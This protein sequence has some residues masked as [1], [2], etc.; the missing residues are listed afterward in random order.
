MKRGE[1]NTR[2]PFRVGAYR[3]IYLWGGPGTIRMN[4]LKFMNQPVDED[5]H[6]E[7]HRDQG[8][9]R[10]LEDLYCNWV[11]LMYNWGFPP[12]IEREDWE[13]FRRA[14]KLYHHGGSKVFAYVQ[15]SN[16]VYQGSFRQKD[17][18]AR[19]HRG[20]K[21]YYYS[22]RYM[23]CLAHP[24]WVEHLKGI[25]RGAIERGAD[26]IFFDNLWHGEMPISLF[27]A[28]LGAAGCH[29]ER[30]KAAYIQASG[31]PIPRMIQTG[32]PAV[33][34]Y[35]RW[36]A[37]QVTA[38]ITE[39]A[40]YADRLQPGT[41]VSANDYDIVMRDTYVVFGQDPRELAK[42]KKVTMVENFALPRW[43]DGTSPRLANNAL[44][45][46][47]SLPLI[48]DAH[49]SVLSYDVGIGFDPLYPP[50][51]Y[52]QGIGEA[53]AC[54]ASMTTKGTEYYHEGRH[55]TLSP[56][57]FAP[58]HRAIGKY[59]RWLEDHVSL[60]ENRVNKAPVGLLYPAEDLWLDWHRLVP[61]YLGAG[62]AL[63]VEGIPWRVVTSQDKLDDLQALLVF[64][65]GDRAGLALP[66]GLALVNVPELEGWVLRPESWVARSTA[67]R[68]MVGF[69][70]HGL[71]NAYM[72]S[73]LARM[74]F[75]GL[76][77]PKLITQTPL[78]QV[79]PREARQ[80]LL[81]ALPGGL[82]P[83]LEAT[84]LAL[85]EVWQQDGVT[86]VHLV[87]Y[88]SQA[89]TVRVVCGRSVDARA[90]SPDEMDEVEYRGEALEVPL[91]IYK[92]L[93]MDG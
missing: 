87:N 60:Y 33:R 4:R 31:N 43:E 38:L 8:A 35:L 25:I 12:E 61:V 85:I 28:W 29:C 30:C 52:Q 79:P 54:G 7:V 36:R 64:Y 81:A 19:D 48:G 45:I 21:V 51:R 57:E 17:W 84:E 24:E 1:N 10:V 67:L 15:T 63:L 41:P 50:R 11:H 69:F 74:L 23:A 86:Q 58:I 46:R 40:G 78:F 55:T 5:A 89:Q 76:G 18:Y 88:A 93:L 77:L 39:L 59:Q 83:R 71:M 68:G 73:K 26:G 80:S 34:Q 70:T 9:R 91:D 6:H 56:A 42:V 13:D 82:H 66:E 53:A 65:S 2:S 27:G 3:P 47:N 49:L 44:T 90:L 22:R 62:Q 92:I 14:A 37:D 72:G 75:D 32:D 20:R 16:C